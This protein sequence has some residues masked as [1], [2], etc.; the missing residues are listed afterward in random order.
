MTWT[1]PS[2]S[3]ASQLH[4][5]Q[6]A[7]KSS[8]IISSPLICLPTTHGNVSFPSSHQRQSPTPTPVLTFTFHFLASRIFC[9]QN[10][11]LSG[12]LKTNSFQM[13]FPSGSKRSVNSFCTKC[14]LAILP[15]SFP[16]NKHMIHLLF[17]LVM[18]ALRWPVFAQECADPPRRKNQLE[19]ICT[20]NEQLV[21]GHCWCVWERDLI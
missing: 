6:Q 19:Q 14:I 3:F 21:C 15:Y 16:H 7:A 2:A 20:C 4:H 8:W 17:S 9:H 18:P 11:L 1:C 12:T 13:I 5:C 10:S